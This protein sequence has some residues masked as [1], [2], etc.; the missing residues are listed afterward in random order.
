MIPLC[1]VAL[2]YRMLRDEIDAA[3]QSV[4]SGGHYILGPNVKALEQEV[5]EL[6]ECEHGIGVASGTDALHLALRALRIGPGDEVITTAF[7]FVA[8]T[9]A[10]G[11]VGATPRFVDI[12]SR[13]YNIDPDRIQEAITPQTKAILPVHLYGQP[14]DM[15]AIMAVARKHDLKVIEDCAQAIGAR[16]KGRPVGSFGDAG[17]FS[18]FPSK[19][20][21]GIGDGGMVTTN[22][23]ETFQRIEMLRRHGGRIKY[24]HQELGLNSRLDEL[25]AAVLRVKLRH[26]PQ[27]N[28]L[29]RQAACQYN[30][31]LAVEGL[32]RRP[33]EVTLEG[34][35]C[36]LDADDRQAVTHSVYHQYTIAIEHRDQVQ[37][38]LNS[39]AIGTAIYYPVP[40]HQQQ[41]H[42]ALRTMTP[43][44]PHCERAASRVL[45]LPMHPYLNETEIQAVASAVR[46]S[47]HEAAEG[48]FHVNKAG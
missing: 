25:Q 1:D 20:L 8:T 21:G 41:V 19:N 37:A 36:I 27:W 16:W 31:L 12:D 6:V 7:T 43:V 14:C 33:E 35:Q 30:L 24:H 23:M 28:E 47:V 13:T 5:A 39:R 4:A 45:S 10:I 29:R 18:F 48:R 46:E 42:A 15:D 2:Q 40:L 38:M 44:L 9:E 32:V 3:M 17:C 22:T 26:L 11:L 34:P